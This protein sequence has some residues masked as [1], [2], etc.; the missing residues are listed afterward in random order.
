MHT[1]I[2]TGFGT[3]AAAS[4]AATAALSPTQAE[5]RVGLWARGLDE[6]D[7]AVMLRL[8]QPFGAR[9]HAEAAPRL[10]LSMAH[11]ENR[12]VRT[13][14]FVSFSLASGPIE[15]R[16]DSP[17]VL[18]AAGDD[19]FW[20]STNNIVFTALAVG[21]AA[22]IIANKDADEDHKKCRSGLTWNWSASL[23]SERT[24]DYND[25]LFVSC[26]P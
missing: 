21:A 22:L 1:F 12:E 10:S 8:H 25:D 11:H 4:L 18:R 13:T 20:S 24:P 16:I 19:G 14:D 26:P 23:S 5:A 3:L 6:T 7:N 15:Q 9:T 17:F 2:R